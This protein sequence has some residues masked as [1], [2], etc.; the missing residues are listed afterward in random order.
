MRKNKIA[1]IAALGVFCSALPLYSSAAVK[2]DT[3]PQMKDMAV[4]GF[5][6]SAPR[7]DTM[8]SIESNVLAIAPAKGGIIGN[9]AL[10]RGG[11]KLPESFDLRNSDKITSMK[12]QGAYG[13]CWAFS[14]VASGETSVVK[15]NPYVDLSELHTAYYAYYGDDQIPSEYDSVRD[16]L[17]SGGTCHMAVNL[18]SQWIGP[19]YE[20]RLPY[21][22]ISF[23]NDNNAVDDMRNLSDYHMKNGYIFEFNDD[24][25]DA[26]EVNALV[27]KFLYEG[28]AVGVS[29]Q[30][31]DSKFYDSSFNSSRS[32]RRPKYANHAVT[33]IGWDD[34]FPKENFTLP[35]ENDGAWLIKN[36]WG[37][38]IYDD[39]YMWI[40]YEDSSLCEFSVYELE[41]KN[42]YKYNY[43]HD[44]FVPLQSLFAGEDENVNQPSYMANVFTAEEEMQA[45]AVMINFPYAGIEYE[46][47]I[48][49][50]LTNAKNP[51]SGQASSVTRGIADVTGTVTVKLDEVVEIAAGER[52][53]AVVKMYCEDNPYVVPIESA[54]YLHDD[55]L[56]QNVSLGTFTDYDGIKG[57]TGKSESFISSNGKSWDDIT[58]SDYT[59]NDNEKAEILEQLR[60][61]LF[62]DIYPEETDLLAEAE[63]LYSGY[64]SAFEYYNL[65]IT[66]GNV[67]LK[68]LGNPVNTVDYSLDTGFVTEGEL[69]EL[70]AENGEKV[71]Y[72]VNGGEFT[73]YTSPIEIS[74][75]NCIKTTVDFENYNSRG[76]I[77]AD[78]I[79]EIGDANANGAIDSVDASLVLFHYADISTGGDGILGKAINDYSDANSDGI[80]DSIDASRILEI[81]AERSTS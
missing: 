2:V 54:L 53:S 17:E 13:T 9:P 77:G 22:N 41:D 66:I 72:S 4:S 48:Y 40:S 38:D 21:K 63:E 23:F 59:Y 14:A 45:E 57:N 62:E 42:N 70:S 50:G 69:L 32:N 47:T 29:Y 19:V 15:S 36:S 51:V 67:A 46:I 71:Y 74:G 10:K 18:W 68:V 12:D 37:D 8:K 7:L 80:I 56:T 16:I 75:Y 49:S 11:E 79:P 28:N 61:Q 3:Q 26:D 64:K 27:K 58:E 39:G 24:R 6:L 34:N 44:T 25:T 20:S 33:I 30:S 52:F 65:S 78:F 5:S 43:H 1:A 76:F 55:E 60:E 31:N 35:A 81:Y 73:E